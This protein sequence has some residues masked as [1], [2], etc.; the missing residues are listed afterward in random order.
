[1][2]ARMRREIVVFGVQFG[3]INI[4][5]WVSKEEEENNNNNVDVEEIQR[6]EF[7]K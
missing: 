3:K 7:D 4:V 5:V 1:M 2:K 6:V